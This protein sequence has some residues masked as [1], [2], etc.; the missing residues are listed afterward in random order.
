MTSSLFAMGVIQYDLVLK[1]DKASDRLC[2]CAKIIIENY[3][4]PI[5]R[6]SWSVL[7]NLALVAKG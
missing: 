1:R 5:T 6:G 3:L 2:L 7:P 4:L